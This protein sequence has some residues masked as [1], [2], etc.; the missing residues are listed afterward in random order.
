RARRQSR[1]KYDGSDVHHPWYCRRVPHR[2]PQREEDWHFRDPG[3]VLAA[4]P[5]SPASYAAKPPRSGG[6][7]SGPTPRDRC[8]DGTSSERLSLL[9]VGESVIYLSNSHRPK[10][11]LNHDAITMA[12]AV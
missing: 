4:C 1:R 7:E 11:E 3:R 12:T 2:Q 5:G 9:H 10:A 6:H 8:R